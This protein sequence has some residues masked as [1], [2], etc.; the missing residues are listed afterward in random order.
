MITVAS[1]SRSVSLGAAVLVGMAVTSAR[2]LAT[3]TLDLIGDGLPGVTVSS[4]TEGFGGLGIVARKRGTFRLEV[5]AV[6]V[7]G[8][9]DRTAAV[10]EVVVR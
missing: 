8:C 4:P 10:R 5:S 9:S 6:D 3:V 1:W 2:P 7:S